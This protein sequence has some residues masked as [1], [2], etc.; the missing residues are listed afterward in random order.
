MNTMNDTAEDVLAR[1]ERLEEQHFFQER[2]ITA[3]N[4]ALTGQ[5]RQID[6][7]ENRTTRLEEKLL[8]LWEQMDEGGETTLPPHYTYRTPEKRH[9]NVPPLRRSL[10]I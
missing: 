1:L 9:C 5:Q 8:S 3:L 10:K 6:L 2:T 7:L 4:E